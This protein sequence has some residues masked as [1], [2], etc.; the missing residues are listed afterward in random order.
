MKKQPEMT[1]HM[2]EELLRQFLC[3]CEAEH[4]TPNNQMLMMIRNSVQY[5]ERAKGRFTKEK[6][7]AVDITPYEVKDEEEK[8]GE[9]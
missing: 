1:V 9:A 7:A 8:Q 2:S 6:L 4:R 5:F 3:L